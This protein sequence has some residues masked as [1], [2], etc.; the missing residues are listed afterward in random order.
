MQRALQRLRLDLGHGGGAG[1]AGRG[2]RGGRAPRHRPGEAT[3]YPLLF[4]GTVVPGALCLPSS[5][6]LRVQPEPASSTSFPESLPRSASHCPANL[7]VRTARLTPE[8]SRGCPG[9]HAS[10]LPHT[11][12]PRLSLTAARVRVWVHADP[13]TGSAARTLTPA[14]RLRRTRGLPRG[15]ASRRRASGGEPIPAASAGG[16]NR[17]RPLGAAGLPDFSRRLLTVLLGPRGTS[18]LGG[19]ET[20]G[21]TLSPLLTDERAGPRPATGRAAP[22][23]GVRKG[24][25]LGRP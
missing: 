7:F 24:P 18:G 11:S 20:P 19:A 10:A 5:P 21:V 3:L 8:R 23:P 17:Q 22:S 25:D 9:P 12:R 1:P 13:H 16:G 14:A 15:V 2:R 4:R 6:P